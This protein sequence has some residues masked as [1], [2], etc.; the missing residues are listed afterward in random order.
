MSEEHK[1]KVMYGFYIAIAI[2]LITGFVAGIIC[3]NSLKVPTEEAL[4]AISDLANPSSYAYR[5]DYEETYEIAQQRVW[6]GTST[7]AMLGV[8][9]ISFLPAFLIYIKKL[10]I[11]MIDIISW[12]VHNMGEKMDSLTEKQ[13][14]TSETEEQKT[15][16]A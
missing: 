5:Y 15:D 13:V 6:T 8:W 1:T 2:I 9:C 4:E 11:E 14:E 3:G 12:T 10:Q 16:I 7:L